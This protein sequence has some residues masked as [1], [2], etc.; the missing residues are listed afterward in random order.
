MTRNGKVAKV[1]NETRRTGRHAVEAV[2]DEIESIGERATK[3]VHQAIEE[4]ADSIQSGKSAIIDQTKEVKEAAEEKI[5][6]HPYVAI[7][8][9]FAAGMLATA[10]L[11][12]TLRSRE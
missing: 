2:A 11:R 4:V 8:A 7:G 9:A 10:V 3:L 1:V 5:S 12:W 6:E